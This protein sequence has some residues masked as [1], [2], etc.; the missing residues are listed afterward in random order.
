MVHAFDDGPVNRQTWLNDSGKGWVLD[1]GWDLPQVI[2]TYKGEGGSEIN[3]M[4][5]VDV[6]GDGFPDLVS[7]TDG[8]FLNLGSSGQK[9]WYPYGAN[10]LFQTPAKE[11]EGGLASSQITMLTL[12]IAM[13]TSMATA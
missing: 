2:A 3:N 4:K 13:W 11:G 8:T 6:N 12:V 10:P 1:H 7:A 9:G 5:L